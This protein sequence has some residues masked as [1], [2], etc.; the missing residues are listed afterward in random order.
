MSATPLKSARIEV[1]VTSDQKQVIERAAALQGR[2]VTDFISALVTEEAEEVVQSTRVKTLSAEAF[3]D[4]LRALDEPPRV[5][6]ELKRLFQK[7][8][9]WADPER[10]AEIEFISA[11]VR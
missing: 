3:D 5:I 1:R 9:I 7:H 11:R 4:F 10:M 8:P 2:S 6:P